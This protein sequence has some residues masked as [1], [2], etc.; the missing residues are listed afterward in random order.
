MAERVVAPLRRVL[1]NVHVEVP[2]VVCASNPMDGWDL[3]GS[4]FELG[5]RHA[6]NS[7]VG[8]LPDNVLGVSSAL[9]QSITR[10]AAVGV[11]D[12]YWLA[13]DATEIFKRI[14]KRLGAV[15]HTT[16]AMTL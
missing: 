4:R 9:V 3:A 15:I 8:G 11:I 14:H 2:L 5:C 6:G 7:D 13:H 16:A 10:G 12:N 1:A